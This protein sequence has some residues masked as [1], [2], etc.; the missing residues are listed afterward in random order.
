MDLVSARQS[1]FVYMGRLVGAGL[2]GVFAPRPGT[3]VWAPTAIGATIGILSSR[4]SKDRSSVSRMAAAGFAGTVLGLGVALAW[5][6]GQ[7]GSPARRV[8][9]RVNAVRDA[10]WLERNPINYA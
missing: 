5:K 10:R 3:A 7:P 4:W 2:N 1:D 9:Q 8:L 6:S